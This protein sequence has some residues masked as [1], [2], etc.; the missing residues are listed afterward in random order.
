[1]ANVC[2]VCSN[3]KIEEI[4]ASI[5]QGA[6]LNSISNKYGVSYSAVQRHAR[7]CLED[8]LKRSE[9]WDVE[10]LLGELLEISLGSAKEARTKEVYS[11]IG[12]IMAGPYKAIEILS[13]TNNDDDLPSGLAEMRIELKMMRSNKKEDEES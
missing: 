3:E 9:A 1:M 13:K 5:I 2:T 11:A 7:N 4:N 8:A 12:P 10:S 6:K